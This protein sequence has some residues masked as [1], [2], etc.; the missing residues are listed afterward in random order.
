MKAKHSLWQQPCGRNGWIDTE[1]VL[2]NDGIVT[3]IVGQS[4]QSTTYT[5][6]LDAAFSDYDNDL[7]FKQTYTSLHGM[8]KSDDFL[9]VLIKTFSLLLISFKLK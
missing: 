3:L 1:Y 5:F 4:Q 6:F 9:H 7:Q 8:W 2:Y